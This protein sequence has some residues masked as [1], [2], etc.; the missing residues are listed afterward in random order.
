L[1]LKPNSIIYFLGIG[2]TAMGSLAGLLKSMGH[3][4]IGSDKGV[5]PP[6]SNLLKTLKIEVRTPY[7]VNNIEPNAQLYIIGNVIRRDNPEAQWVLNS[8][9]PYM[10][11]PQAIAQFLIK[12]RESF[13]IAGT[14][15]KTTTTSMLSWSLYNENKGLG[16]LIGGIPKD[17]PSSFQVPTSNIFAIEGDEYDTVFYDKVPKFKY[18]K[19]KHVILTSIEFDHA[20]IYKDLDE[21]KNAFK[22]LLEKIPIDGTLVYNKNDENIVSL[23]PY[24]Q[25]NKIIGYGLD[26]NLS[27]DKSNYFYNDGDDKIEFEINL[28]GDYNYENAVAVITLLS[29]CGYSTER[30][31]SHLKKFTGVKRRQEILVQKN[32][33]TL[34]E[35]FA[36]HPT[37]VKKTIMAIKNK[38]QGRVWALF[39]PRSATSRTKIFQQDYID[40]LAVADVVLVYKPFDQSSL[41]ENNKF[42]AKEV[43]TSL[44]KLGCTANFCH[45]SNE[46]VEKVSQE[47]I[48]GDTI[49]VMSNGAFDGIYNKLIEIL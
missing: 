15:G 22:I 39:E 27:K 33:I 3:T 5:Y 29:S 37:S 46:I 2:G 35:D 14:H 17:L 47:K 38:Y 44:K 12:D 30:I 41:E 49:I 9:K 43:V 11:L 6:M 48:P 1:Q 26:V 25:A 45:N 28:V 16:Y 23:L 42:S 40:A 13:V 18:Y 34:I 31:I 32:N 4:I 7:D 24:C 19:P 8:G 21:V 20:D 36:H 10:S